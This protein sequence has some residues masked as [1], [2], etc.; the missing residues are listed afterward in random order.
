MVKAEANGFHARFMV[1]FHACKELAIALVSALVL[2]SFIKTLV[3][4]VNF[5]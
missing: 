1:R 5:G 3:L 4:Q 2:A